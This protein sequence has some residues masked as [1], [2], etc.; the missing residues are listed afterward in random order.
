MID[1]VSDDRLRHLV[2]DALRMYEGFAEQPEPILVEA[3]MRQLPPDFD[4]QR[5]RSIIRE[6]NPPPSPP[7]ESR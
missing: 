4:R 6:F 5:V 1:P 3:V 7:G 2:Q